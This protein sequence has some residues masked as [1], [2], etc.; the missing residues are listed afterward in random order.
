[1]KNVFIGASAL[2]LAIAANL[3]IA[4]NGHKSATPAK[5]AKR[6]DCA[7]CSGEG[8]K[9]IDNVCELGFKVYTASNVVGTNPIRYRCIYHY[10]W[11]DGSVSG[12]Y[13]Q[14]S[15]FACPLF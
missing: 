14:T 8:K 6:F 4:A 12:N 3:S 9:C 7:S 11:T 13:S 1:M 15:N 10:E 2:V 5:K